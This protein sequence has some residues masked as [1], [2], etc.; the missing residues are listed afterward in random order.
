MPVSLLPVSHFNHWNGIL[1]CLATF[2][3]AVHGS[4]S[5][6]FAT[7]K[8]IPSILLGYHGHGTPLVRLF[9]SLAYSIFNF[10]LSFFHM[11][12]ENAY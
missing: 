2:I 4:M 10:F 11:S 3:L 9:V 12:V 8:S 6:C 7:Q 5:C 1:L